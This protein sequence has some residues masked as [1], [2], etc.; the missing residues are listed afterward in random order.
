[1]REKRFLCAF[2]DTCTVAG[3]TKT[4]YIYNNWKRHNDEKI[5]IDEEIKEKIND[6]GRIWKI[7]STNPKIKKSIVSKWERIIN[8]WIEGK[9]LPLIVR[10]DFG[11]RGS[12][13]FHDTG[14]V[15]IPVDNSFSQW[16]YYNVLNGKSYFIRRNKSFLH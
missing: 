11:P 15:I 6:L 10:K 12:E 8:D 9:T 16:I 13:F 4:L 5:P 1:M 14:R 2:P 3:Y 7:A